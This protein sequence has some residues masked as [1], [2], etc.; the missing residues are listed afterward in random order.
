MQLGEKVNLERA[1]MGRLRSGFNADV[2]FAQLLSPG[3]FSRKGAKTQSAAA[4]LKVF[5][6][7]LR[8]KL[9]VQFKLPA[10]FPRTDTKLVEQSYPERD[11]RSR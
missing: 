1:K 5:F 9:F 10:A 4:F 2:G 3:G 7:P 8:E 6:A 11:T